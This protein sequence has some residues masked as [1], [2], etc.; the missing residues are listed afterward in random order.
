MVRPVGIPVLFSRR[1]SDGAGKQKVIA[2]KKAMVADDVAI[3]PV[4]A[5]VA[6]FALG[7]GEELHTSVVYF[8]IRR[9]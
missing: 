3:E 8:W 4:L 2:V 7:S 5:L 1:P 6:A 9:H